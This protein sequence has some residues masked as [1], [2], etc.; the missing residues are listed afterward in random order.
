MSAY[1]NEAL[2][3]ATM[4]VNFRKRI[5]KN[6]INKINKRMVM[7]ERKKKE[8]EEKS[9]RKEEEKESQIKNKGKLILD[10]SCAP[11]DLSYPR[12]PQDLGILNQARKKTENILDCLYQSLRIKLKKKPRT[13]R[14]R[15]RKDY[16]KVAKKRRCSQKERRE[17]IKKQLQYI[18]RNLS[19]MD[20]S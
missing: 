4:F 7:R 11:A 10:A 2:F 17:A 1:S 14:K 3:D 12:Y 8:I 15:A 16:L 5:S 9:E 19:Q 18:K 20:Q 13:Y 6:L